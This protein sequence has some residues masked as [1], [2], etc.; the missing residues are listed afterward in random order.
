MS[1]QSFHSGAWERRA[2]NATEANLFET[3]RKAGRAGLR[4]TKGLLTKT[5]AKFWTTL[6]TTL[7]TNF[8][9]AFQADT[10]AHVAHV[11]E[12]EDDLQ[13]EINTYRSAESALKKAESKL[14]AQNNLIG[15]MSTD[16]SAMKERAKAEGK[17]DKLQREVDTARSKADKIKSKLR[18]LR[19]SNMVERASAMFSEP[20]KLGTKTVDAELAEISAVVD[21]LKNATLQTQ[22]QLRSKAADSAV[23]TIKGLVDEV[24][25]IL[26][27]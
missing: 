7:V 25:G 23:E 9:R 17:R 1:R 6:P 8:E 14:E 18:D 13:A 19:S 11:E 22:Q 3:A 16:A 15:K 12:M 24:N 10:A 27:A 20:V 21:R 4:K 26:E 2:V 5:E